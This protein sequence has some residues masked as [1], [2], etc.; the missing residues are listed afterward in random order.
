MAT[1]LVAT[2]IGAYENMPWPP[3]LMVCRHSILAPFTLLPRASLSST[4]YA[5]HFFTF[6]QTF[7][8]KPFSLQ[9]AAPGI[10]M[11]ALQRLPQIHI[12]THDSI[13]TGEDGPTHQPIA[14]AALYRA[15]PNIFHIRPCDSEE[16]AGAFALALSQKSAPSIISLS[17]QSLLQYPAHTS[18]EGVQRGAYIFREAQTDHADVTLL[19]VGSEITFVVEAADILQ[20]AYGAAARIV[21][22]PC[23]RAFESQPIE[24]KR[25]VL[26]Y[27]STLVV[28][29]EAY[30]TNG[31]ERYADAG[32]GMKSFGRSLPGKDTYAFFGFEGG[33]IAD[34][35]WELVKEVRRDGLGCLR[36]EFRDL[37]TDG[38]WEGL[39]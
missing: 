35:V 15:M 33:K 3:C 26:R 18:R 13:G 30:A 5:I 28:A 20:E 2:F 12:A 21:S 39:E 24:Y 14:L 11:G 27:R 17:R 10:R 22:F 9:Y 37:N 8:D 1:T 32:Y 36:G 19:G 31:W 29:V 16:T 23:Q 4:L 34:R 7:S 25:R 6:N 38:Y